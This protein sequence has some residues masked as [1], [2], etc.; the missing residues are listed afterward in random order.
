MIGAF[1]G[2]MTGA[3]SLSWSLLMPLRTAVGLLMSPEYEAAKNAEPCPDSFRRPPPLGAGGAD[4]VPVALDD[5]VVRHIGAIVVDAVAAEN[6]VGGC[7]DGASGD[8][9][10]VQR[11][12]DAGLLDRSWRCS[13]TQSS[14]FFSVMARSSS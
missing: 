7:D 8:L 1:T 10:E 13:T 2:P 5:R 14:P 12:F 9:A 11:E 4:H 3:A 6:L